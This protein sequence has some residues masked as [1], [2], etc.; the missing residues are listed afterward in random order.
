[1]NIVQLAFVDEIYNGTIFDGE[2]IK[3]DKEKWIFLINDIA[4]YKGSNLITE[5]FNKRL[6]IIDNI[7]KNEFKNNND[8]LFIA[9]KQFF[10]YNKILDLVN[11]FQQSLNY[12]NS[13]LYFKNL[14]NFSDNYLF[15]FPECRTDSKILNNGVT[16]DNQKVVIENDIIKTN[17]HNNKSDNNNNS[18]N[19]NKIDISKT[20][21]DIIIKG[22]GPYRWY[23]MN[24]K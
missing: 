4:Y 1:M 22:D 7:L 8:N 23:G 6:S 19:Y 24:N 13:G 3:N 10:S 16:I 9:Q 12:K 5:N 17:N 21:S 15:I 11:N 14:T 2:I 18:N 20:K